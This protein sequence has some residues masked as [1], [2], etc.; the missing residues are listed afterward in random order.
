MATTPPPVPA[1]GGDDDDEEEEDEGVY[2]S[3]A[4][5][6]RRRAQRLPR[7]T[8]ASTPRSDDRD[9]WERA[10][11]WQPRGRGR[12]PDDPAAEYAQFLRWRQAQQGGHQYPGFWNLAR[13]DHERT[14]AGPP[15]DWD[16]ENIDFKDYKLK[17]RIWLRTTRTPP[18]ARGPLLLK[19]LTKGPWEDL[20]FLAGQDDW[21]NNPKNG[22]E[23]INLMNTKEFYGEEMRED[24]LAACSRITYHLRRS[25]GEKARSFLTRWDT[26]ER[27][28][29]DH[30]VNLPPE[31]LGFLLVNSLGLDGDRVRQLLQYTKGGLKV[32]EIKDWLRVQETDLDITTLGSE[33]KKSSANY[34]LEPEEV[35]VMNHVQD[36]E[37]DSE[38]DEATEVL[39]TAIQEL[40]GGKDETPMTTLT[41]AEAQEL[42]FTMVKDKQVR[43]NTRT[44]ATAAKAKKNRDLA[45]GYG[46]GRAG[47]M[48]PGQYRVSIAE[49]KKRT[50]CDRCDEI[51][52]WKRECPNPPKAKEVNY[53]TMAKND[54]SE[55]FMVEDVTGYIDEELYGPI[56]DMPENFGVPS[57]NTVL[58][59]SQHGSS[60]QD[61]EV[62]GAYTE[63][64]HMPCLPWECFQIQHD[65]ESQCATLDTGCQRMAI[66]INTL[67]RLVQTQPNEL[68][69]RFH[70]ESHSFR[71][72][73]QIST[74]TR[75]AHIPTS[76]GSKGSVLKPAV[77]EADLGADAPFLLSLPFLRHC[78]TVLHLDSHKGLL[79]V[80]ERFGFSVQLH[81][82][83]TGALRV[84]LQQFTDE[85]YQY[86]QNRETQYGSEYELFQVV[87]S[88]SNP[89]ASGPSFD[90]G[91][92]SQNLSPDLCSSHAWYGQASPP[93]DRAISPPPGLEEVRATSPGH[94]ESRHLPAVHE[95]PQHAWT[96]GL[97][98][99]QIIDQTDR[100]SLEEIEEL[101]QGLGALLQDRSLDEADSES[102]HSEPTSEWSRVTSQGWEQPQGRGP[103][104]GRYSHSTTPKSAPM[105]PPRRVQR[106]GGYA[107]PIYEEAETSEE[108]SPETV[109]AL[110]K[111]IAAAPEC[112]CHRQAKLHVSK[113]EKNHNRLFWRCQQMGGVG[114]SQCQFFQW[115]NYQPLRMAKVE[116]DPQ[117]SYFQTQCRHEQLSKVGS[118]FFRKKVRCMVC[119]LLLE[120]EK[121]NQDVVNERRSEKKSEKKNITKGGQA[122]ETKPPK[123]QSQDAEFQEFLAW[124]RFNAMS[125]SSRPAWQMGDPPF[126]V[127]GNQSNPGG[128]SSSSRKPSSRW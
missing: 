103:S 58:S 10:D 90:D 116:Q 88:H 93:R 45:R 80:S 7:T 6:P 53:M 17:A 106:G 25:K 50:K 70:R 111:I 75:V 113:T 36:A 91:V 105:T 117:I 23:L 12:D 104:P 76:L 125:Q 22:E 28:V 83:P 14:T 13:E 30:G 41:E 46:A 59:G 15:P 81:I 51:G 115:L 44:Y 26:A 69:I 42:L 67:N 31:Y 74:T 54:E 16:G 99:R 21:L 52:H 60:S 37:E 89:A 72:V 84:P 57:V 24:M 43:R 27:K 121:I 79:L 118:N 101:I 82:G 123:N 32:S 97:L 34:M 68:P 48:K 55:I 5:G 35:H 119:G 63:L 92:E 47:V 95:E 3:P 56:Y 78:R 71:S 40:E 85:M 109:P 61:A 127:F 96:H 124:K 98:Y 49:I 102:I 65:M 4:G 112:Y 64:Q 1:S 108:A 66:G 86:L 29:R 77:F 20:K 2:A 19:A 122:K 9:P 62:R 100:M 114:R 120:D 38:E 94:H 107:S 110:E 87:P 33:K 39:M 8:A 18:S 11:P 73:H 128:P 126:N